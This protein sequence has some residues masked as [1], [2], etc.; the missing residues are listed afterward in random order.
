MAVTAVASSTTSTEL[1]ASHQGRAKIICNSDAND[2]YVL[3]GAGT[4]SPSNLSF[5]VEAKQ[6]K[7]I[8]RGYTGPINGV[9]AADGS[10]YAH[11]TVY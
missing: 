11:I 4:A 10:G 2:L 3:L 7:S 1:L 6:E 8:P 9:W 5:I